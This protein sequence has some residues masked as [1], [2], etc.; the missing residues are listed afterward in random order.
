MGAIRIV[1]GEG[2]IQI[3]V[4]VEVHPLDAVRGAA[5]GDVLRHHVGEARTFVVEQKVVLIDRFVD[6]R[7]DIQIDSSIV[8]EI[9]PARRRRQRTTGDIHLRGDLGELAR[10]V[11]AVEEVSAVSRDEQVEIAIVVVVG[12]ARTIAARG[13]RPPRGIDAQFLRHVDEPRPVVAEQT[14][15]IAVLVGHEDVEIAVLI[16]VE[17][18]GAHGPARI[19]DAHFFADAREALA[20]VAEEH[21]RRIAQPNEEIEVAV[22]VEIDER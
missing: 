20:V 4:L 3:A 9:S 2:E 16:H 13:L 18:D 14:V 5:L 17:P 21:V 10:P 6:V 22:I 11:V 12:D 15:Q 1:V 19:V 7:G 8:V